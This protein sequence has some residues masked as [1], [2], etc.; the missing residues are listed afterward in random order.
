VINLKE[1][2]KNIRNKRSNLTSSESEPI[3]N[4][5]VSTYR[6]AQ[7]RRWLYVCLLILGVLGVVMKLQVGSTSQIKHE[8]KE[9]MKDVILTPRTRRWTATKYGKTTLRIN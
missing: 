2:F 8:E 9:R 3:E 5:S 6:R 7:E 1:I 4:T